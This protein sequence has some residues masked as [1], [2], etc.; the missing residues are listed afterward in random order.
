MNILFIVPRFHLNLRVRVRALQDAGHH[1]SVVA[2]R[3]EDVM[4]DHDVAVPFVAEEG[5]MSV[6]VRCVCEHLWGKETAKKIMY[7][8]GVPRI[9]RTLQYIRSLSPETVCVRGQQNMFTAV[10]VLLARMSCRNVYV[11]AQVNRYCADTFEKRIAL[12]FLRYGI[13][14]QGIIS[15][16][17]NICT[18]H[19]PLYTYVP[20]AV[21]IP[22]QT[23]SVSHD[24]PLRILTVG[25]FQ[26]RK[27]I[28]L[29]LA[30]C[31][32][33]LSQYDFSLTIVGNRYDEAYEQEVVEYA[34]KYIPQGKVSIL[35]DIP[36]VDMEDIFLQHDIFVLPSYD[37]PAAYTPLEAMAYGMPV[38]VSDTCGTRCYL[39]EGKNG[40]VFESKNKESLRTVILS[41]VRDRERV[42][43]MGNEAA[44]TARLNH[45]PEIFATRLIDIITD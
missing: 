1:V 12:F 30:V 7:V 37:E 40:S 21:D 19:D 18:F 2:M 14:V 10:M 43:Q 26:K 23:C 5:R 29:L 27:D 44:K 24:G 41:L 39:E 31:R 8:W 34:S 22:K 17:K 9:I 6:K 3:I 32:E 20:F 35:R 11:L 45:A 38:I 42:V 33:L 13:G 15:P 28:M 4:E 25:K 36:H 16:L